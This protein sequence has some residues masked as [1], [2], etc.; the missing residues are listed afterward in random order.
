MLP[1]R[2][3]EGEQHSSWLCLQYEPISRRNVLQASA[4]KRFVEMLEGKLLGLYWEKLLQPHIERR[5]KDAAAIAKVMTVDFCYLIDLAN[6]LSIKS[7]FQ[8]T[9][10]G[11]LSRASY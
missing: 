8:L 6:V 11:L 1:C 10:W 3:E 7:S 9:S 5:T 4:S 2:E